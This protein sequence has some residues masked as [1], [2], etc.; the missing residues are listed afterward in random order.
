MT[1]SLYFECFRNNRGHCYWRS[2]S[3]NI[4]TVLTFFKPSTQCKKNTLKHVL[5]D[6]F[7]YRHCGAI[8]PQ[9]S[10]LNEKRNLAPSLALYPLTEFPLFLYFLYLR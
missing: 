8:H 6:L 3:F 9:T 1:Y 10:Q 7:T 5:T 2:S 4:F